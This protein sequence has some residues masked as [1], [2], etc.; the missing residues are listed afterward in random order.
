MA[1]TNAQQAKQVMNEGKPMKKIK[2][3]DHMLAYITPNEADKL[4]KLGG[5][6][7]MTKEGIPAYPEF[8][9]YGF[10]SQAD[11][12]SGDVSRSSDANVRGDAPGQNRVTAE[13]LAAANRAEEKAARDKL[14]NELRTTPIGRNK[15]LSTIGRIN[16]NFQRNMNLNLA[17]KR[18]LQKL[19]DVEQYVD[20]FDDYTLTGQQQAEKRGYT[21][22]DQGEVTGYDRDKA[23][24]FGYDISGQPEGLRTLTSNKGMSTEKTRPNEYDVNST[25][26]GRF[27]IG[28]ILTDAIRPDTQVT[29]ENTLDKIGGY[30][31]IDPKGNRMTNQEI[32]DRLTELQNRGKTPDQINPEPDGDPFIPIIPRTIADKTGIMDQEESELAK[33]MSNRTAYRFMADGGIM[34]SDVVGGEMDF[35]SARQMYGLGKLVKK[36]TRS[37]KKIV[38]SPIGKAALLYTGLGGLGSIA[39]GGTFFGNFMSPMSQLRGV[40]SIFSKGGLENIMSKA[41]LGKFVADGA[42]GFSFKKNIVGKALTSPMGLITG[43]SLVAGALTAEQ[44]EEAQAIS[45]KTGIDIAEIRANPNKYLATRFKAEGGLMRTK[46]AEGSKDLEK[47]PE[48]K[49]WKKMYENNPDVG[50]MHENHKQYLNFYERNKNKQ[51]EGSKEPVAKETMPLLDMDGMEK[52]YREDGGFVPIGR[53]EKADDVPARLSKNEFVFTADAVRNAGDGNVDKG[54]EVM[55]NMMKN[56][57]SGGDVSEESQG[58]EGAKKMFQTSQ[59]LEEV[60]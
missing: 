27:A 28:N 4:V 50:A 6:K 39:G 17:K 60:I 22:N 40:G 16:N 3:Q 49:G 36:V 45:D 18:A 26:K 58:L 13:Q 56:L 37:V 11:F 30:Q 57:E 59:R 19:E 10:S 43:A 54:A 48:Y 15:P 29:I 5:Q 32:S 14:L 55:Y 44:E 35:E 2:G 21:F 42:D 52:D 7:T 12:D 33:M 8:D 53:M 1:I 24:T 47:N 46:Y 51:A 23:T 31:T 9:N 41:K 38:K 34:N 20:P 25:L